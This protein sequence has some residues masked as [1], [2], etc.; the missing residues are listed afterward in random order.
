MASVCCAAY[1][2]KETVR[3]KVTSIDIKHTSTVLY[4]SI[5][6]IDLFHKAPSCWFIDSIMIIYIFVF[7]F[8]VL[9][10]DKKVQMIPDVCTFHLSVGLYLS[11]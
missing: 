9:S 7:L 11:L 2:E 3:Q 4:P 5:K 6:S 1:Y 8:S 10:E